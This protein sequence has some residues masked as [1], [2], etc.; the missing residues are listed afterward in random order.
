MKRGEKRKRVAV[1]LE[2]G[3]IETPSED[4]MKRYL[5]K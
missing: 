1:E 2:P 5:N 4:N 3:N